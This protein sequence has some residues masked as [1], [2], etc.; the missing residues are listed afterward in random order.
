MFVTTI[1][2]LSFVRDLQVNAVRVL[3][4]DEHPTIVVSRI[5]KWK[6]K[7]VERLDLCNVTSMGG[8][9]PFR[10]FLPIIIFTERSSLQINC[11]CFARQPECPNAISWHLFLEVFELNFWRW[12]QGRESLKK[13]KILP[14]RAQKQLE[15]SF[16]LLV[17]FDWMESHESKGT[18]ME[19][20]KEYGK[21]NLIR[22]LG[23]RLPS[24]MTKWHPMTPIF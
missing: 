23:S 2:F 21:E 4:V 14:S 16:C 6:L 8:G 24:L 5:Q 18:Y 3:Q 13:L 19:Y 12:A 11:D 15:R 20:D 1:A 22:V 7:T 17:S 9:T 10:S